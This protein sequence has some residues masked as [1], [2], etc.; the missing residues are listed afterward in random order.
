MPQPR[1][2][3]VL[4]KI[5]WAE[6]HFEALNKQIGAY[7]DVCHKILELPTKINAHQNTLRLEFRQLPEPDWRISLMIGDCVHNARSSLDHLWKRLRK[8]GNFPLFA[9]R[10]GDKGWLA[11]REDIL[12][13]IPFEAHALIDALQ[14]C[15]LGEH[16]QSHPLAIL[17]KL[18][19]IDKHEEIHLT[20]P[21]A[22]NAV[23]TFTDESER[24]L[25][26]RHNPSRAS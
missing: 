8:Q 6:T 26:Q 4:A 5:L 23:Y 10:D 14:P 17:N 25:P 22:F 16:A 9:M 11:C 19:R 20:K 7:L 12:K 21:R 24:V 15:T 1:L 13:G 3:T 18:D 2:G